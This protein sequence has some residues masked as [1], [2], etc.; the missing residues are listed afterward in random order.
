MAEENKFVPQ[1]VEHPGYDVSKPPM[2]RL[3]DD[4]VEGD[5]EGQL[6][7]GVK[8]GKHRSSTESP[9]N[10]ERDVGEHKKHRNS[11]DRRHH[12]HHRHGGSSHRDY[13]HRRSSGHSDA[14]EG[15]EEDNR[16]VTSSSRRRSGSAGDSHIE[17]CLSEKNL[18]ASPRKRQDR[19][20]GVRHSQGKNSKH[21]SAD[22]SDE[23][24]LNESQEDPLAPQNTT[25]KKRKRDS[26][27]VTHMETVEENGEAEDG[28]IL[29]DGELDDD[30]G[31]EKDSHISRVESEG[32]LFE[33]WQKACH[34]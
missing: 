2:G 16:G 26:H 34:Y 15:S 7:E 4:G 32:M 9:P 25:Q 31:E 5:E 20:D 18:H 33:I 13:R 30:D 23:G 14:D 24:E 19:N 12:H 28:E 21:S 27:R 29:E 17:H 11:S 3:E 10:R 6:T 22:I 8:S 1:D